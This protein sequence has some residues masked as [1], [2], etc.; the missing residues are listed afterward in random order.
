MI[1]T[2]SY[3]A[4]ALIEVGNCEGTFGTSFKRRSSIQKGF[5]RWVMY[6]LLDGGQYHKQLYCTV[7]VRYDYLS[8]TLMNCLFNNVI[9]LHLC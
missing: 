7:L 4:Y 6:A 9:L 5:C 2:L 1:S 8:Y 3:T